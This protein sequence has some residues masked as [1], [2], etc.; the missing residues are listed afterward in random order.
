MLMYRMLSKKEERSFGSFQNLWLRFQWQQNLANLLGW[1]ISFLQFMNTEQELWLKQTF[2]LQDLFLKI[3][4]QF[5]FLIVS[6]TTVVSEITLYKIFVQPGLQGFNQRGPQFDTDF[7][8]GNSTD[9]LIYH[10]FLT[11][12][13]CPGHLHV[14]TLVSFGFGVT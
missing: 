3:Q 9:S 1:K 6:L 7:F 12:K 2:S 13:T 4:L 10:S 5:K 11:S 14:V 8:K